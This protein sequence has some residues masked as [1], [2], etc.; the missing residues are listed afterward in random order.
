MERSESKKTNNTAH[1]GR[2]AVLR[3]APSEASSCKVVNRSLKKDKLMK[4]TVYCTFVATEKYKAVI[5][6]R[7]NLVIVS[8]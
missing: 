1:V 2:R 8:T 7:I 6:A 4:Q 5:T 3:N